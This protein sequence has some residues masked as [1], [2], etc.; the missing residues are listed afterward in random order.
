LYGFINLRT[1]II[2]YTNLG[3]E[4]VLIKGTK[5]SRQL[6]ATSFLMQYRDHAPPSKTQSILSAILRELPLAISQGEPSYGLQPEC[7]VAGSHRGGYLG[8]QLVFGLFFDPEDGSDMF[9]QN[10]G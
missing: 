5:E 4:L 3:R 6:G 8:Y 10:V 7:R 9:P 2:H 1:I